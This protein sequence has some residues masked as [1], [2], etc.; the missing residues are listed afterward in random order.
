MAKYAKNHFLLHNSEIT[1]FNQKVKIDIKLPN[2]QQTSAVV[3]QK[4]I[5]S[6]SRTFPK[7]AATQMA[8]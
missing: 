1:F 5:L 8:V 6:M 7:W 4:T 2:S 3:A